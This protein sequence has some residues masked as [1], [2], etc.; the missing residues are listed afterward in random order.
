[1]RTGYGRQ[2]RATWL[3]VSFGATAWESKMTVRTALIALTLLSA[4]GT[5]WIVTAFSIGLL[6]S[7]DREQRTTQNSLSTHSAAHPVS[8][9][10]AT[11]PGLSA[12]TNPQ[13]S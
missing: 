9:E 11:M 3:R 6:V 12:R 4:G 13:I 7:M 5:G 1:M 8:Q 10:V 2:P